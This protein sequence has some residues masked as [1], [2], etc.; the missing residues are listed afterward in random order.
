LPRR[1]PLLTRT[2]RRGTDR[3][4]RDPSPPLGVRT[5]PTP[6]G[7]GF[8][9]T[10]NLGNGK[11]GLNKTNNSTSP[12]TVTPTNPADKMDCNSKV[13]QYVAWAGKLD[14][15]NGTYPCNLKCTNNPPR[16]PPPGG[17]DDVG[18]TVGSGDNTSP[19][20]NANVDV[21]T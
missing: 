7:T 20:Y 1:E 12:S 17:S 19:V 6:T 3:V 14:E 10:A 16:N 4:C 2:G 9:P 21:G 18:V 5:M 13:H 11:Q 15:K 8:T